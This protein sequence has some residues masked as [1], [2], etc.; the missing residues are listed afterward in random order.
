MRVGWPKAVGGMLSWMNI[1]FAAMDLQSQNVLGQSRL[2]IGPERVTRLEPQLVKPIAL[3]DWQRSS[4]ELP[5]QAEVAV[6][7]CADDIQRTF[8]VRGADTPRFFWP[9]K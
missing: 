9:P 2:L 7:I 3:D 6:N 8:L 1:I 4:A 5:I